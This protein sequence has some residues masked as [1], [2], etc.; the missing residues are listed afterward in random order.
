MRGC[1]KSCFHAR[2]KPL[3]LPAEGSCWPGRFA[4]VV[5]PW[6]ALCA[7]DGLARNGQMLKFVCEIAH[8]GNGSE[9]FGH[10]NE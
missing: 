2:G 1:E 10:A 8:A 6:A 5:L 7:S 4:V 9:Q 3:A